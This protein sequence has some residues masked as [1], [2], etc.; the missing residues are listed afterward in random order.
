MKLVINGVPQV[1][2]ADIKTIR[3]VMRALLI[4]EKGRIVECNGVLIAPDK[5][6][7]HPVLPN[8]KIEIIQFMG[9]G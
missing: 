4:A 8:D 3:C 6:K 9:G 5:W 1:F 7:S 2:D